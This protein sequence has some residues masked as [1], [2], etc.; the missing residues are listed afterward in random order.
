M[1]YCCWVNSKS[2]QEV[3]NNGIEMPAIEAYFSHLEYLEWKKNQ[4]K[5]TAEKP[6]DDGIVYNAE[7]FI[8]DAKRK[9]DDLIRNRYMTIETISELGEIIREISIAGAYLA[10][11]D[12]YLETGCKVESIYE[13]LLL[14]IP[15]LWEICSDD[16]K[17][18]DLFGFRVLEDRGYV[19]HDEFF[20]DIDDAEQCIMDSEEDYDFP[21]SIVIKDPD[22]Y[23]PFE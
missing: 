11:D 5:D 21:T 15:G 13:D 19:L 16:E 17:P 7:W 22:Y 8:K 3:E 2:I 4:E 6:E 23:C 9:L 12:N 10:G 14:D 20:V 1:L 18:D